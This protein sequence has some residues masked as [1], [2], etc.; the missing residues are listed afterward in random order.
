MQEINVIGLG[1]IGLPTSLI[2]ASNGFKVIGTDI[3]EKVV[4]GLQ[5]NELPFCEEGMLEIFNKAKENDIKFTTQYIK[6]NKYIVTVPT[7]YE[8]RSKRIDPNFVIL[9]VKRILSIC[10]NNTIIVIES[11]I[12]PG[13]INKYVQPLIE[14]CKDTM[15]KEIFVAHAPERI[16][17]G[18]TIFE[19]INNPRT[20]GSDDQAVAEEVKS[21]YKSFCKA[22]IVT[23]DIKTAELSKVVENTYRDINIAFANELVKICNRENINVYELIKTANTHPRVNIL[24]PGPGVGGHCISVD[25]WFLVGDYPDLVNIIL[26]AR[27]VNESMPDYVIDRIRDV[28]EE[29]KIESLSR[30][31]LYGITYKE[32]VDDIRE[33][34]TLQI[35]NRFEKYLSNGIKV[36][37]PMLENAVV[38]NQLLSFNEFLYNIDLVVILVAH[39]HLIENIEKL[40]DKIILD[41]KNIM[42]FD[43]VYK[44]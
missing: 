34:P 32:N 4:I 41:T 35:L 12:S 31:G 11:T 24:K 9:A 13:T 44:L 42:A 43:K 20:I 23:T 2:F 21:W 37:D 19:L 10:E 39:N 26:A 8:S 17:P 3:N 7:P 15:N 27:N 29:N 18:K 5:N 1:Y 28:M 22:E 33:S 36:Y 25:P 30:V 14:E 6:S 40:E 16:I 38:K